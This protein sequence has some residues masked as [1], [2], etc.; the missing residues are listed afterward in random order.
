VPNRGRRFNWG[1][2]LLPGSG[3][4]LRIACLRESGYWLEPDK[5]AHS[6]ESL[7]SATLMQL[8]TTE[9]KLEMETESH[10]FGTIECGHPCG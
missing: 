6:H 8:Y 1:L 5:M 4:F 2:A 7:A 10:E 3:G 9:A